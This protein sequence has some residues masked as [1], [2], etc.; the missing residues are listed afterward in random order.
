MSRLLT[1]ELRKALPKLRGQEGSADPVV[2][3]IF[4]FPLSNWKWFV[5][6]GEP[7]AGDFTFF[8]YVTGFEAE[9][10]Y[11][12]LK[13]LEDINFKGIV[14]ERDYYFEAGKLSSCSCGISLQ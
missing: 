2:Y 3:A 14:I 1:E 10:G 8:G 7:T 4:F 6:E 12:T 11:F 13:E 9:W 5:T